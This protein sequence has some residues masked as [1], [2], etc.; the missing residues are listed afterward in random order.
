LPAFN[1]YKYS[2]RSHTVQ[3]GGYDYLLDGLM[4]AAFNIIVEPVWRNIYQSSCGTVICASTAEYSKEYNSSDLLLDKNGA[5]LTDKDYQFLRGSSKYVYK[6]EKNGGNKQSIKNEFFIGNT[7]QDNYIYGY[8]EDDLIDQKGGIIFSNNTLYQLDGI[9]CEYVTLRYIAPGNDYQDYTVGLK[10]AM[11]KTALAEAGTD[12]ESWILPPIYNY[13]GAYQASKYLFASKNRQPG[14]VPDDDYNDAVF[15]IMS[16][17]ILFKGNYS[18]LN[19][20]G[21]KYTGLG[22]GELIDGDTEGIFYAETT[23]RKGYLNSRGEWIVNVSKFD[24][25]GAGD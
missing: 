2:S 23:T 10:N 16:G 11:D 15:D 8:N 5:R 9:Y 6:Y 14:A 22:S 24:T 7:N 12:G 20:Y 25:I 13:I 19:F 1:I 4:D 21:C 17:K 3:I 18:N